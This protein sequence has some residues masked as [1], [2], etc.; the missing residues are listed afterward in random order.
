VASSRPVVA[1]ARVGVR[2]RKSRGQNFLAQPAIAERIVAAAELRDSDHVMEIGPGLGILTE[3]LAQHPL[4]RLTLIELEERLAAE[5]ATRYRDD[6]RVEVINRDFLTI[7]HEE[8]AKGESLKVVGN[9]PFNIA[10]AMLERLC[11]YRSMIARMVLMFQREVAER[12]RAQP[13]ARA[14]GALSVFTALYWEIIS[15]FR[16]AAG[17]F[18]PRPTVDAEVL[19]FT[20]R[21]AATF[22][23]DEE[24]AILATIRAAFSAPRKTM[25]NSLAGGWLIA[26]ESAERALTLARIDPGARPG[27]LAVTDFVR[28]AWALESLGLGHRD[29]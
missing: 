18:H 24:S 17:S 28:L 20:P 26:P 6:G 23:P 3:R 21:E 9:L 29:A 13:G 7:E 12:I 25:R 4:R 15:H 8:L 27:T 14:H 10:S 22:A 5:L 19:V 1:L 16:V 2:P 11:S